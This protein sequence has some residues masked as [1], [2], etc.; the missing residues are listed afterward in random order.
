MLAT[1]APAPAA[2]SCVNTGGSAGCF[3][4]I[5]SAIN[6][7]AAGDT[8]TVAA[9]AY[10]EDITINKA[11]TLSGA[12]DGVN[13]NS[14]GARTNPANESIIH[15]ADLTAANVT[16][17]GFTVN[18][19]TGPGGR[20]VQ[21]NSAHDTVTYNIVDGFESI[22]DQRNDFFTAAHNRITTNYVGITVHVG[23]NTPA[24]NVTVDDN[25]I[26][27]GSAPVANSR[28]IYM[29]M[30]TDSSVTNN[31]GNGFIGAGFEG[32]NHTRLLVSGNTFN[33]NRKG[34]SIFGAS[35]FITVTGNTVNNNH[36]SPAGA[37]FGIDI[38]G[39]DLT[40]TG[41]TITGNGN[42]GISISNNIGI[43]QNVTVTGNT[44]T[45][46]GSPGLYVDPLVLGPVGAD[47]NWWGCVAGPG[48]A[49]CDT[50]SGSA[51]IIPW[52]TQISGAT[53]SNEADLASLS[54]DEGPI[55]PAF[56]PT[57]TS[58]TASVPAG[59]TSV[60]VHSTASLGATTVVTGNSGLVPGPNLVKLTTTSA[61]ATVTNVTS[62]TVTVV[63]LP[64]V[65]I[66]DPPPAVN[67]PA[68]PT[69]LKFTT[70]GGAAETVT[71]TFG[72]SPADVISTGPCTS[73]AVYDTADG[74]SYYFK[75]R[76]CN[77]S[78]CADD[79]ASWSTAP[80]LPKVEIVDPPPAVNAPAGPTSLKFTTSGGAAETV[81]CTFGHSPAD[82]ISTGPCTSPAVYDTA[83]GQSCT[84][85][86]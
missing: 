86:R 60:T 71:C 83:D 33:G 32:S 29:S 6:A 21:A 49:G 42:R 40:I 2:T 77:F 7:A 47:R 58:Y 39:Q 53:L 18:G 52:Y 65:E 27:P 20:S 36:S 84:T 85:S 76:V 14:P 41:N 62:I 9:G 37:G 81:T 25:V 11:L 61:D 54:L 24:T 67:A 66:V 72:H 69:S 26:T 59:T 75:V 43:T 19:P 3:A 28:A 23:N 15:S 38:K 70:S 16:L 64:K 22:F 80:P 74:Q 82:V 51:T 46:N 35:T 48:Q 34:I 13:P 63:P 4:S 50:V 8:I 17:S 79:T 31:V 1:A 45:G 68:G 10:G 44:I 78:G 12:Q 73:P 30:T 56:T 57:T 5:Q 55:S